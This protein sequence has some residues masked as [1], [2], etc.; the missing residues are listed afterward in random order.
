MVMVGREPLLWW[1][2]KISYPTLKLTWGLIRTHEHATQKRFSL[3]EVFEPAAA[4]RKSAGLRKKKYCF[5]KAVERKIYR[6]L[7]SGPVSVSVFS[8]IVIAKWGKE[9]NDCRS[10]KGEFKLHQPT[11]VKKKHCERT[12]WLYSFA[13][14]KGS[15]RRFQGWLNHPWNRPGEPFLPLGKYKTLRTRWFRKAIEHMVYRQL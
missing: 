14:F 2:S 8:S 5:G 4:W 9:L 7:G 1:N 10:T 3:W 15:P 13:D 12:Q 6:Q 11:S